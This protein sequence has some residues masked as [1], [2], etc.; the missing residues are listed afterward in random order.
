[1]R[2]S[3]LI[4]SALLPCGAA[5]AEESGLKIPPLKAT[6]QAGGQAVPV[7]L[8]G[9]V[10]GERAGSFRLD[11]TADLAG[12]Q[13]NMTAVLRGEL[14]RQDHCG[15]RL[16][17]NHADL[18]P[19]DP[20]ATLTVHMRY[21]RWACAKVFGK[22]NAKRLV[23]G[24]AAVTVKL[25]P[26]AAPEGIGMAAEVTSLDADGSLG[27]A[28]RSGSVGTSVKEKIA[29]SVQQAI[30][31]T[32]ELK[33]ALPERIRE[34]VVFDRAQFTAGP[35]GKLWIAASAALKLSHDEWEAL[36]KQMKGGQ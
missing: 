18:A 2:L 19:A 1:M 11:L 7:T 15:E 17:V 33:S 9:A 25:T 35:E 30:R 16:S 13:E 4:L 8:W 22:E 27:E 20:S 34:A 12:L 31:K 10:S 29:N 14:D 36:E 24:N 32:L 3:I 6:V 23:G 5:G 28:L 21:E 26:T